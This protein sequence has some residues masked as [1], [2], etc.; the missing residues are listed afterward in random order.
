MNIRPEDE[1]PRIEWRPVRRAVQH[2]H[3]DVED[4]HKAKERAH[5]KEVYP[6]TR[7]SGALKLGRIAAAAW[8]LPGLAPH[9][10]CKRISLYFY[11]PQPVLQECCRV[12]L[13]CIPTLASLKTRCQPKKQQ[14]AILNVSSR[15]VAPPSTQEASSSKLHPAFCSASR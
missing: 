1:M 6:R 13:V 9:S 4:A 2:E 7:Q 12:T 5:R 14:F 11:N 10:Y 8:A 15:K 3:R